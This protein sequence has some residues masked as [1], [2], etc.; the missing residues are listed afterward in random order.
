MADTKI[1]ALTVATTPLAGTE[2][3]PIVQSGVTKQVSVANLTAG[4]AVSIGNLTYTGTL[5]GS[6]S[7]INI[8]SNQ[9]VK[10]TSGNF[11]FNYAN[12]NLTGAGNGLFLTIVGAGSTASAASARI[13]LANSNTAADGN[14]CGEVLFEN[15]GN[16]GGIRIAGIYGTTSGSGGASGY[17]GKLEFGTKKDNSGSS[18]TIACTIDNAQ[19]LT[20]NVGNLVQG[21]AA[22]GINFTANTP[23]AGKTSQLLN[24][25]EEG[26]WTP[27]VGVETNISSTT[28]L[29]ARYTRIG[30]IV[31]CFVDF[32]ATI[33]S[34]ATLTYFRITLPFSQYSNSPSNIGVAQLYVGSGQN[35]NGVG[36]VGQL[37]SGATQTYIVFSGNQVNA[38]GSVSLLR[39]SFTYECS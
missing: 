30:R 39:A 4:R 18:P 13:E 15:I 1:S 21:T 33:T 14:G 38:S 25:Y 31:Y 3:L 12:A 9:L 11:A 20:F 35:P 37:S 7:A 27:T 8:G 6:T 29:T 2:V 32:S 22:K 23:A 24:W 16:N 28:V 17:G 26:T 34:A 5:T 10:D 19:N 36:I